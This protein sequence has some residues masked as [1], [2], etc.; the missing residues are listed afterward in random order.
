[1]THGVVVGD[2]TARSAVL[3]ARADR[4]ATLN[5][6][7]SGG[8]HGPVER[9]AVGA[10][11]YTGTV[12]LDHSLA[13]GGDVAGQ[14][15]C[16]DT[17]EGFPIMDTIRECEPDVFVGLGDMIYADNACDATGGRYGN[18]QIGGLGVA[19]DLAG[20]WEHWR[21]NRGDRASQRSLGTTSY[22]GVWDDHEVVN[23]F[24][25]LT[26]PPTEPPY[27]EAHL[28]PLDGFPADERA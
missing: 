3:W 6:T 8:G 28:L 4:A 2:V 18:C 9:I 20:F 24:G 19:V 12:T 7:L 1:M 22:V 14:N 17:P 5:V 11:D 21:H 15:V 27:V 13:F 16:R 26:D 10:S 23:D 25:P